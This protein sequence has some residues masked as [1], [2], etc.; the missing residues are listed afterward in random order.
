MSKAALRYAGKEMTK[1]EQFIFAMD[2]AAWYHTLQADRRNIRW[3]S[4]ASFYQE[5]SAIW[6]KRATEQG[7]PEWISP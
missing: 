6:Y 1:T 2:R 7:N 3:Y 4:A 5:Q